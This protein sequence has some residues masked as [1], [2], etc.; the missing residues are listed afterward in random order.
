MIKFE[1][2]LDSLELLKIDDETYFSDKYKNYISNS[3]LG[4]INPEQEG[5]PDK[6]FNSK[7]ALYSSSLEIGSCVHA[8]CLQKELYNVINSV[9]KPTGKMGAMAEELFKIWKGSIPTS[10]DIIKVAKQI[11]YYGGNLSPKRIE[12][13]KEKCKD[14]W[15]AKN[16]HLRT[17]G[18]DQRVDI[19][20]DQKSRK[21]SLA[22]IQAVEN[23]TSIQQILHP[24]S[25]FG[26][27]IVTMNEMAILLNIKV[28]MPD[29]SQFIM[30]LKS[31]LDNFNIDTFSNSIQVND[32]KTLGRILS[33]FQNNIDK[34]HYQRELAFYSYLLTL[35]A[36]K[37]YNLDNPTVSGNFLVVSTIPNYYTK[38]VPVTK[39]D[40][41]QGFTEFKKLL[42]LVANTIYSNN[43]DFVEWI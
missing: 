36:K 37:F 41:I 42:E 7:F 18:N 25:E 2:I 10:E 17:R 21:T 22:C 31:K 19:Y 35:V 12:E 26:N 20:L 14:F 5:S 27:E 28:T 23:N 40:F 30:K 33:E 38:V 3:R 6:F 8:M 15:I 24:T 32:L 4:L 34:Y 11:D 9:N 43:R 1:P 39:K 13:V 16:R 29:N